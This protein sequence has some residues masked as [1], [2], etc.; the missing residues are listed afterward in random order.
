M[1]ELGLLNGT[2]MRIHE[3]S[4]EF[5]IESRINMLW[6]NYFGKNPI[7]IWKNKNDFFLY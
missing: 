5:F 1:K 2:S 6:K 7:N 3:F 4:N